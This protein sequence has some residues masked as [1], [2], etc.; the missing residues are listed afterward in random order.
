MFVP[1]P[2][3]V[4]KFVNNDSKFVAVIPNGN[5]LRTIPSFTNERAATAWTDL[6]WRAGPAKMGKTTECVRER[7]DEMFQNSLRTTNLP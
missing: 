6:A 2:N 1:K 3:D 7:D 4:T 5:R